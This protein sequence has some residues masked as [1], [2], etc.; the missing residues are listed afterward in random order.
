MGQLIEGALPR[1]LVGPPSHEPCAVAEPIAG[2]MIVLHLDDQLRFQGF[3]FRGASVLQRLGPPGA[4]PVNPGGATRFSRRLVR[5][6]LSWPASAEVYPDV[7]KQPCPVI[8]VEEEGSDLAAV[9]FV[10]K[11]TPRNPL[12]G[13]A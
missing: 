6:G 4:L 12:C 5:A 9:A 11:A 1:R 13:G 8:D 7:M 3:P 2:E 10:A